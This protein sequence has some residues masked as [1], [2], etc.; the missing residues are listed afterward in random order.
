[1][2]LALHLTMT[3]PVDRAAA[4]TAEHQPRPIRI[5]A[6]LA[7]AL[8]LVVGRLDVLI[9]PEGWT[10]PEPDVAA[11]L[12]VREV[13]PLPLLTDFVDAATTVLCHDAAE[14]D[15]AMRVCRRT[16]PNGAAWLTG[17]HVIIDTAADAALLMGL[18]GGKLP[19]LDDA[20]RWLLG[21]PV[22]GLEGV[23]AL[24]QHDSVQQLRRAAA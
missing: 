16:R 15:H 10:V 13:A 20:T 7:D 11:K 1:M 4:V 24:Y 19:D 8:G 21:R 14:T 23:L 3:G 6:R 2:M 9:R 17:R 5:E 12:G 18:E 22:A